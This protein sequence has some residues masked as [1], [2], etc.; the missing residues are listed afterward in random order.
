MIAVILWALVLGSLAAVVVSLFVRAQ[1][2]RLTTFQL[3]PNTAATSDQ[4]ILR[5]H[6]ARNQR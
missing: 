1:T 6:P 5:A 3:V 2:A 4:L